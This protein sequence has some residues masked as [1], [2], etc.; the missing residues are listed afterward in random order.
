MELKVLDS[1]RKDALEASK[2]NHKKKHQ[3]NDTRKL[4]VIESNYEQ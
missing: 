1:E 3:I 2:N 4:S